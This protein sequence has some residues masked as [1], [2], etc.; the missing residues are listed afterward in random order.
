MLGV[1]TLTEY[2]T[3]Q[4]QVQQIK[5]WLK[6]Y[7]L[8]IIAGIA[9]ALI[10]TS[11]WRYWQN[12]R[13]KILT[14][15]SGVYDEMLAARAQGNSIGAI[16]QAKKL[17]K[18]YSNTPYSQMAAFMLARDAV[19][20]KDYPEAL[21]Q[22]NWVIAHS[23]DKSMREIARLRIARILI[24]DNKPQDSIDSL[25][26]IDD[27]NFIGLILEIKGDAY[28]ALNDKT[29]ARTSYEQALKELPNGEV[30]RPILQMKLDN[31][32]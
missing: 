6:Q 3:E 1:F 14:H 24:A 2:M 21:N 27:Q 5:N 29:A 26:K 31:L 15:A 32:A 20:K 7:G 8:T 23:K 16:V 22:L 19:L 13:N 17:L 12:Y 11:G 28:L 9:I 25:K 30:T 4:E 18:N 10:I